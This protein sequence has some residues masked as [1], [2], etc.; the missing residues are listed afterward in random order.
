MF[1]LAML[2]WA[3]WL[4]VFLSTVSKDNEWNKMPYPLMLMWFIVNVA[5]IQSA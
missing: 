4:I 5:L 2:S 1:V 3:C